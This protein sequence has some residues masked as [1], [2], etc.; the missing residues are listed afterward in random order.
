MPA[1]IASDVQSTNLSHSSTIATRKPTNGSRTPVRFRTLVSTATRLV[2]LPVRRPELP[3]AFAH[4]TGDSCSLVIN[5]DAVPAGG[6]RAARDA[7]RPGGRHHRRDRRAR[8]RTT[9]ARWRAASAQVVR[10]GVEVALNRFV[11][12]LAGEPPDDAARATPTS[13][14]ARASTAPAARSTRCWPPTASARG[15]R[16]GA[17]SRR[18]RA[19]ASRPTQLYDLGE[20]IFAYIDEISAESRRGLRRGAVRG[21]GRVPAP[22]PRAAAAARAGAARGRGDASAR[23]R[24]PRAGR[25]RGAS[26]R[27][28][29]RRGRAARARRTRSTPSRSR[30][31]APARPGRGRRGRRRA[32]GRAAARPRGPGPAQGARG[33][34]GRRRWRRSGPRSRGRR[35]RRS[36]RRAAAAFRP[37][38]SQGRP[39]RG[40]SRLR[41]A[42]LVWSSPTSTSRRCCWPPSRR[43]P[44]TSR[45]PAWPR[46]TG[47]APGPRER[48][49]ATLRAWLDRPGQV[50]AVAAALD[51]HPQT[52]RYR[53]KQLREL[54]GAR[55]EDPEAR[56]EL[57]AGP[58]RRRR[59]ALYMTAMRLLVTGAA[60]MLGTDVVA[61]AAGHDVVALARADLDITDADAV[62]AAV[63]DTRP[64]A[65]INC[66]AWTDVDGAE[67]DE[68]AATRINGD[69]AGHLAAAAAEAGA[70]IVHVSTDY[71]FPGDATAPVPRGRAHRP[72]RR[73]RALEARG[74]AR[75]RG[76]CADATRSS[77][78]RGCSARTARTSSTR[79]CGSAPS[80]TR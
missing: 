47:S 3:G 39:P 54:F 55:L 70:H 31:G 9:R 5:G 43:S 59:P 15:S 64:D 74:R 30:L 45:A 41:P 60:G 25:C 35:R 10:F 77:A 68:A 27:S 52:V 67:A 18:A 51:V 11:D 53:L 73:L 61:A 57:V 34:A 19:P 36:L 2:G 38:R 58:A 76:G 8:S 7:A 24:S 14:S 16:G 48:L 62:R 40:Q 46:S 80:A 49:A 63:R 78:P 22:P 33:R 50:Q 56:F 21:G 17:S 69:G 13:A 20:A 65:M 28:S 44:P 79:C 75:R 4:F 26:P 12:L 1:K 23:P 72:D 37:G 71:V 42:S 32:G 29:P 6:R 66:A